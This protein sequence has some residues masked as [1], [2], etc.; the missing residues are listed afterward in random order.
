MLYNVI[1]V[2][3]SFTS[4]ADAVT[5]VLQSIK[6]SGLLPD[7]YF[8]RL[9]EL[10]AKF[11]PAPATAPADTAAGALASSAAVAF[12]SDGTLSTVSSAVDYDYFNY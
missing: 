9:A 11:A 10:R 8:D 1:Y 12:P 6:D 3:Q 5:Q 7:V 4:D 2:A